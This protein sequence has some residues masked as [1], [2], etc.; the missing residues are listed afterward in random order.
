MFLFWSNHFGLLATFT[1][2]ATWHRMTI[3]SIS[4][5]H[6]YRY[7]EVKRVVSRILYLILFDSFWYSGDCYKCKKLSN[8]AVLK[9]PFYHPNH[10]IYWYFLRILIGL[11][12]SQIFPKFVGFF[13]GNNGTSGKKSHLGF[14]T[15]GTPGQS[16][17]IAKSHLKSKYRRPL[18]Q[19]SLWQKIW[20]DLVQCK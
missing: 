1:C 6:Y 5:Y 8:C 2:F 10:Y 11:S 15:M 18:R 7:K 3:Q 20:E 13:T 16:R 4:P 14:G 9:I 12:S 17:P 19:Y